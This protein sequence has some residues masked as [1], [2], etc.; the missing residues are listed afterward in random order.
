[1]YRKFFKKLRTK[2][3]RAGYSRR[4][5]RVAVRNSK[6][7]CRSVTQGFGIPS[8]ERTT[9]SYTVWIGASNVEYYVVD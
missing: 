1:M 7:H 5:A 2:L 9:G 3:R 6:I 4:S 8:F